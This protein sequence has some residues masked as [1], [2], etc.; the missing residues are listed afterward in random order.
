MHTSAFVTL[1]L[2]LAAAARPSRF[3]RRAAFTLANGQAAIAQ[4]NDFKKLKADS[5]CTAGKDACVNSGFAQCV[6]GKFVVQP[7]AGGL[8]CAALPLVNAAGTSITCTTQADVTARIAATGA[9]AAAAPAAPPAKA[10]AAPPAKAPAAPPAKAPAAAPPAKA[11]A[12]APPAGNNAAAGDLQASLTLDPSVINKGFTD[13]GQN[14][15]VKGQTASTTSKNNYI[16]FCALTLPKVPLTNGLQITGGSCNSNPI[17]LIPAV[18]KMPSAKFSNPKNGGKVTPNTAFDITLNMANLHTGVF[19]N[20]QKTYYAAPQ[21]L[22]AQG[23]IIGHTH[24]VIET[25]TALDQTTP[26]DP[27][28]FFFFKGVDN[29]A[30]NGVLTVP[31]AKGVPAGAYRLCTINAS[32]NHQPVIVPVAQHGMLDDCVYFT[33]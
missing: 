6:N 9:T 20:A 7:C 5:P 11:P 2:A 28:K 16:N 10:P 4:N 19:T 26:T 30:V 3:G 8:I 14:P 31:V 29:A 27:T 21:T 15:P 24:L 13:D 32:S 1:A 23:L 33:A 17:G 22:D 25:L 12:A 18:D